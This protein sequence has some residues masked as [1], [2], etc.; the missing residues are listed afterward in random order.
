MYEKGVFLPILE[1]YSQENVL[2]RKC[3][4]LVATPYR[5]V[6]GV[7]AMGSRPGPDSVLSSPEDRLANYLIKMADMGFGLIHQEVM[8]LAFQMAEKSGI[9]HPFRNGSAGCK[10]F[11][12]LRSRHPNLTLR[13]PQAL[14][15]ARAKSVNSKMIEDIFLSWELCMPA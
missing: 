15:Y 14:L 9:K 6:S 4:I 7:I 10:W 2:A 3:N 13:N 1:Q 12:A 11:D 5:R 8:R